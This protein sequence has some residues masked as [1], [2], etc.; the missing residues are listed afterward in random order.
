MIRHKLAATTL[1]T[2]AAIIVSLALLATAAHAA[3]K[4]GKIV[5]VYADPGDFVVELDTQ[6]DCGSRFFHI[7]RLRQNFKEV[8]A[9][10]L[11][12]YAAGKRLVVFVESCAGDRNIL[13]HA[14]SLN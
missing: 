8:V 5:A 9:V 14:G 11:T 12:A 10:F 7:Q 13:T 3:M 4:T 1:T 6:G 2:A